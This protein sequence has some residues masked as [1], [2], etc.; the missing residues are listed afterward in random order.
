M[1]R[2]NR[3]RLIFVVGSIIFMA[4]SFILQSNSARHLF[5]NVYFRVADVA[6]G[7]A[8]LLLVGALIVRVWIRSGFATRRPQILIG[9]FVLL[10]LVV[11]G[12]VL[13]ILN[14]IA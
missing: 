5:Q 12:L 7:G 11:W 1:N 6:L 9:Q 3:F 2:D 13:A 10:A 8:L 4:I 14:L